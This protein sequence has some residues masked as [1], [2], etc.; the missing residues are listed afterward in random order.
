MTGAGKKGSIS[1][2]A[3]VGNGD[4][5]AGFGLG[6]DEEAG[7]ALFKAARAA[8]KK[9]LYVDRFDNRTIF[10]TMEQTF[11]SAPAAL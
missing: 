2:L 9:L 1:V 7:A 10:H 6:K 11:V 8:K 3:V 5:V 4:G